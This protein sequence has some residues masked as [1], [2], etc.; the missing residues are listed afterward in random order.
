MSLNRTPESASSILWKEGIVSRREKG[1]IRTTFKDRFLIVFVGSIFIYHSQKDLTPKK[2]ITLVDC[3]VYE[4]P[5]KRY[6]RKYAVGLKFKNDDCVFTLPN[7]TEYISWMTK[8][9]D[10][11]G[12]STQSL[13]SNEILSKNKSAAIFVAGKIIDTIMN[14]GAGGRIVREYLSEDSILIIDS[15]KNFMIQNIGAD[16]ANKMEKKSSF[17]W[18]QN[19][20]FI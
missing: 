19:C 7:E 1:I 3:E 20:T 8:I 10:N 11:I 18:C 4:V 17:N 9:R 12:K 15:I 5:E 2:V 16:Q 6:K 13:S 14:M